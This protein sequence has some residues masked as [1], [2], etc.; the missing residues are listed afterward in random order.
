MKNYTISEQELRKLILR[1]N[2]LEIILGLLLE[3]DDAIDDYE[4]TIERDPEK[5]YNKH[6]ET[7]ICTGVINEI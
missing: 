1:I 6:L 3:E 4:K 5:I 2:H 7:M